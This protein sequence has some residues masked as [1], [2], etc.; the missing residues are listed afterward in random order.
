MGYL[1]LMLAVLGG[2]SFGASIDCKKEGLA[3]MENTI[4][5]HSELSRL[6]SR[7]GSA[8]A[9]ARATA[10]DDGAK[11]ALLESQKSWLATRDR[12]S[13]EQCLHA[14]YDYRI[15]ELLASPNARGVD[16]ELLLAAGPDGWEPQCREIPLTFFGPV[17]IEPTDMPPAFAEFIPFIPNGA[18]VLD[19]RC[20]D[21][22]GDGSIA[23]LLVTREPHGVPG[24][25]TLLSRSQDGSLRVDSKNGSIIQTDA[26]GMEGG[27]AGITL[28]RKSFA[29]RNT[30][31]S[32]G[33][34]GS[35]KFTFRYV[36]TAGTWMLASID[37]DTHRHG[38]VPPHN[39]ERLTKASFGDVTFAAFDATPYGIALR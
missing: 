14:A 26:A 12:C 8:Y 24:I 9:V 23:Y 29:V 1:L 17:H 6:D 33:T 10:G 3:E 27:Y 20:G 39:R 11:D 36:T 31:G 34:Q 21:I 13:S 35:F 18:K 37:T 5:A 4:C 16:F 32:A 38:D 28:R 2:K 7:L 25:L 15:A 19:L 30:F 22:K